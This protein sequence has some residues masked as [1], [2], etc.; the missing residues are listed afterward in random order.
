MCKDARYHCTFDI[1]IKKKWMYETSKS[2]NT[3]S[4]K[5]SSNRTKFWQQSMDVQT[6]RSHLEKRQEIWT[7]AK[8][9]DWPH[10]MEKLAMER[11]RREAAG[12]EQS[13]H[14]KRL[15]QRGLWPRERWVWETS[16][17]RDEEQTL[18][19]FC[20]QTRTKLL[21]DTGSHWGKRERFSMWY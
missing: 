21:G 4:W 10:Y 12:A 14:S 5:G 1:L 20:S 19:G 17:S 16:R 2:P 7:E 3:P 8:E 6:G 15:K 18:E 11:C 13:Q 9:K